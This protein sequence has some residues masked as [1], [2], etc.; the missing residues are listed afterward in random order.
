MEKVSSFNKTEP[1]IVN[2]Q[3][4]CEKS[5]QELENQNWF[6]NAV[7]EIRTRLRPDIL[8]HVLQNIENKMGRT[9]TFKGAP[10]IIDL[11]LL[12]YGQEVINADGLVI[13][14]PEISKRRFVIEPLYEIAS[15]YIHPVFG[16]SIRGLKERLNDK[17][18]VEI[19]KI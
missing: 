1:V 5:K 17:K 13:P 2:D 19:F 18:N 7:V 15:F 16:V 11:D 4:V 12:F 6:V 9:R 3:P 14:H 10:R 8:L